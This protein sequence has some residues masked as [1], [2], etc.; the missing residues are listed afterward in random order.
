[1]HRVVGA[2]VGEREIITS[3]DCLARVAADRFVALASAAVAER[4][5]FAVA[6]SGGSTPR[7]AYA[8]LGHE[9]LAEEPLAGHPLAGKVD[10]ARVDVFWG[11]ERCVPP[12]HPDS[13]YRMARRILLDRIPIPGENVHRIRGELPPQ[14]AAAAYQLELQTGLGGDGRFDLI[15]LGIGPDGHTASLFPGTPAIGE[16]ERSV[17]AVYV[18]KLDAWRVTLTLAAINA[19]RH[20]IFL[21]AGA[22]KADVLARVRGGEPLPAAMVRPADGQLTWLVDRDAAAR[23]PTR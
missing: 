9:P 7:P 21:V 20:V 23:L 18:K 13:N 19:A 2:A 4:G 5:R 17:V 14:E 15:L 6:L 16:R 22:E 8:L 1:M 11:D 12:D 10:W 3:A